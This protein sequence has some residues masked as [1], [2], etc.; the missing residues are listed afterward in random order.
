M[1]AKDGFL[2]LKR[3]SQIEL[4]IFFVVQLGMPKRL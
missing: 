2:A 1:V 4:H 3:F